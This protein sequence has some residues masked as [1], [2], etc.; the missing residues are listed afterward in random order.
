MSI[1]WNGAY[2]F[3]L[4][5]LQTVV[6]TL[7]HNWIALS[8]AIVIAVLMQVY[9]DTEKLKQKLLAK[10]KVSI[11]ASVVFGAFTPLCACGTMAVVIGMLST[12]VPW[13]AIM[14]FL[15]SSP[16]MS[17]D[18]FIMLTGVISLQFALA[19]AVASVII[20]LSSGYITHLIETKTGFLA[21]QT[22]FSKAP[23][24]SACDCKDSASAPQKRK[25]SLIKKRKEPAL[26]P[27]ACSQT[28]KPV[29]CSS[30][31]CCEGASELSAANA[32]RAR[33]FGT[34]IN[35][36]MVKSQPASGF[37]VIIEKIKGRELLKAFLNTGLKQ[38][39]LYFSIFVAIGFLI[40]SF[41]PSSL[42]V[43][44]F[45]PD[46]I[47]AVPLAAVIGL[48][49]YVS[50][51]AAIPLI[52]ALMA[53]GAG[54]GAMLAFMITGP[55]TSAWVIAGITAFLKKRAIALY[56]AYILVGGILLGYLYD[57]VSALL[58]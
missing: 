8:L 6:E 36:R 2:E 1:T 13:G 41:I 49:L 43:A 50:G 44:L 42:I 57:F 45:S 5:M 3:V 33:R 34:G 37:A 15:T 35:L 9:V 12:T 28:P 39:L 51:D 4:K 10:P 21:N 7:S 14:A 23:S 20:G 26:Q 24:P 16:L 52:K 54:D 55:A 46:S 53:G 47:F 22:R 11:A 29:C 18:G 30:Q 25:S 27:C 56:I 40:N 58:A 48:P 17:P 38:I 19:L 32:V 31:L